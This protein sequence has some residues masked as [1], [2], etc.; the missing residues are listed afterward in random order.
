[1][2][3]EKSEYRGRP[4][5]FSIPELINTIS[6]H[7]GQ[8]PRI[9][10]ALKDVVDHPLATQMTHERDLGQMV[11]ECVAHHVTDL[12]NSSPRIETAL[13]AAKGDQHSNVEKAATDRVPILKDVRTAISTGADPRTGEVLRLSQVGAQVGIDKDLAHFVLDLNIEWQNA[14]FLRKRSYLTMDVNCVPPSCGTE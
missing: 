9:R 10:K 6:L 7:T 5:S 3:R 11:E 13:E 4:R 1:M 12:A 14:I 8:P 2:P